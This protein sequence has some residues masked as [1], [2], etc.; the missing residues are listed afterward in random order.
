M[1]FHKKFATEDIKQH[2]KDYKRIKNFDIIKKGEHIKYLIKSDNDLYEYRLGGYLKYNYPDYIV[3]KSVNSIWSV[4]KED[5][6]FFHKKK[7]DGNKFMEN[8]EKN[9]NLIQ[10]L[11]NKKTQ[12]KMPIDEIKEI[13]KNND[14]IFSNLSSSKKPKK[15]YIDDLKKKYDIISWNY[16][17]NDEIKIGNIIR[18]ITLTGDKISDRGMVTDINLRDNNTIQNITLYNNDNKAYSWKI[19]PHK[20]YLFLHPKS[21]IISALFIAR[22]RS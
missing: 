13:T 2:L 17:T 7:V 5:H 1:S 10:E 11:N 15:Q 21:A 16:V 3:L 6:I 20:Y 9:N 12:K 22:M 8:I 18:Y 19:K 4:R 14:D